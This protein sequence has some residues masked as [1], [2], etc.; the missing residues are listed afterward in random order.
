MK[1]KSSLI[2]V[3]ALILSTLFSINAYAEEYP[4]IYFDG[5]TLRIENF[6]IT[7]GE[8]LSEKIVEEKDG[9]VYSERYI[10]D[11]YSWTADYDTAFSLYLKSNG[12][13]DTTDRNGSIY[14]GPTTL[15][16]ATYSKGNYQIQMDG[17]PYGDS[18]ELNFFVSSSPDDTVKT[19]YE[20]YKYQP[21]GYGLWHTV[22]NGVLTIGGNVGLTKYE[23]ENQVITV[24]LNGELY[25]YISTSKTPWYGEKITKIIL[26]NDVTDI[27]MGFGELPELTT[28]EIKGKLKKLQ[29]TSLSGYPNLKEIHYV[30][31][32]GEWNNISQNISLPENIIIYFGDG[33]KIGKTDEEK[34]SEGL[35]KQLR[36]TIGSTVG[37]LYGNDFVMDVAPQIINGRT[38]LPA[39]YV[40][41]NLGGEIEWIGEHQIVAITKGSTTLLFR[42]GSDS[43][44]LL[45]TSDEYDDS[46]YDIVDEQAVQLNDIV[47]NSEVINNNYSYDEN[48]AFDY[49]DYKFITDDYYGYCETYSKEVQ[50]DSAPV[51]ISGRTFMPVRVIATFLGADVMWNGTTQTVMIEPK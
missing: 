18:F 36:M 48:M 6:D 47:A 37:K 14:G 22:E 41:E 9:K 13:T 23:N 21:C 1:R 8:K 40:T 20:G 5:E 35:L 45:T 49:L 17:S 51:L 32:Q 2:L 46:L 12:W 19:T 50:L 26:E 43:A 25:N 29:Y 4:N 24:N 39:R 3:L 28:I 33:T 10:Y 15:Y 42:I 31:T 38:M 34:E 11:N 7:L 27:G 30:G 44:T 16:R